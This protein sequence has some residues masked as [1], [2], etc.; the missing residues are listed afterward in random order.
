M[1]IWLKI[2]AVPVIGLL[3]WYFLSVND[4]NFGTYFLSREMNDEFFRVYTTILGV[5]REEL[6]A[7][8]RKALVVDGSIIGAIIAY[9]KRKVLIPWLR[10]VLFPAIVRFV[11]DEKGEVFPD[12]G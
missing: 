1:V 4:I 10:N 8:F 5:E 6:P 7:M 2:W 9:R 11:P 3:A 12:K